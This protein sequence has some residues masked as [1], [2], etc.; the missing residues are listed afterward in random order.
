[1]SDATHQAQWIRPESS[2]PNCGCRMQVYAVD[3]IR[4]GNYKTRRRRCPA[5]G[6]KTKENVPLDDIIKPIGAR[7]GKL[8]DAQAEWV[9]TTRHSGEYCRKLL[10]CSGQTISKIR[11]RIFYRHVRPDLGRWYAHHPWLTDAPAPEGMDDA[12]QART[13]RRPGRRCFDCQHYGGLDRICQLG[14]AAVQTARMRAAIECPDYVR[15][16]DDDPDAA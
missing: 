16:R 1:M 4:S 13:Q 2:C 10:D 7:D 3:T 6:T 14:N 11:R 12:A 9:L 5:C 15:E 8:T